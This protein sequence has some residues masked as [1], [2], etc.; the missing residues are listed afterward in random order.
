LDIKEFKKSL[1]INKD[2]FVIGYIGRL[3][4][5]KNVSYLLDAIKN[6]FEHYSQKGIKII[7]V[8]NGPERFNLE[9]QVN[10]Y[11]LEKVIYFFDWQKDIT[12]YM[13][14]LNV[15]VLPSL[16]EGCPNII[17]EALSYNVVSL[18]SNAKGIKE[19][20]QYDELLFDLS[21]FKDLSTKLRIIFEDTVK[22]KNM[23]TLSSKRKAIF[24]FDWSDLVLSH[25][26]GFINEKVS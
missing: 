19:V 4:K 18:G 21:D 7:I 26:G 22:L 14:S 12:N 3:S 15:L 13:N 2:D 20:L 17:L 24:T 10:D 8:G 6:V 25:F 23:I 11:K 1:G 16:Y 9:K 5:R